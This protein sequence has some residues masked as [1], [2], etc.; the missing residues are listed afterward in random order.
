MQVKVGRDIPAGLRPARGSV[1]CLDAIG[2]C[3]TGESA[4]L[5]PRPL[6]YSENTLPMGVLSYSRVVG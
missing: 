1:V 3:K 2:G 4:R 5:G 6:S